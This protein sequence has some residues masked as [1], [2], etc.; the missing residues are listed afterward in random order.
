MAALALIAALALVA[1]FAEAVAPYD[2]A[3]QFLEAAPASRTT[4]NPLAPRETGK[5]EAPSRAHV[6]GTDQLARDIFSRMVIGLRISLAAAAISVVVVTALGVGIGTLAVAG[7]RR[8]DGVLM[9]LTDL[10]FAFPDLLLVILLRAALDGLL[11]G[12]NVPPEAPLLLLFFAIS[13]TAWPTMA[14]LVRG[15]LLAIR[16]TEYGV[17]ARP[18]A[19]RQQEWRGV[20][21]CRTSSALW[22]SRQRSSCLASCS[23]RRRCRSSGS[24]RRRRC[25]AWAS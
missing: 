15:Q 9:R 1:V 12:R 3:R 6:L 13:I 18:S 20:T 23:R 16:V 10:A 11:R 14:R 21:G 7:P 4:L 25:R 17:A 19:R 22:S 2:S 24:R 5:F 8:L